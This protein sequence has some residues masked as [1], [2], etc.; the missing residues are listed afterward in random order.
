MTNL[1]GDWKLREAKYVARWLSLLLL[2]KKLPGM[3]PFKG[4]VT[5]EASIMFI[6][7]NNVTI[8]INTLHYVAPG[9]S[10]GPSIIELTRLLERDHL[11]INSS[12]TGTHS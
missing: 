2:K 6:S 8:P 1:D 10:K 7:D 5:I 4:P 9:L 12:T 3:S 11:V